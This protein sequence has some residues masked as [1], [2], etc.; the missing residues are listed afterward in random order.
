M[1]GSFSVVVDIHISTYPHC[2]QSGTN[3]MRALE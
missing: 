3:S 1:S 2:P